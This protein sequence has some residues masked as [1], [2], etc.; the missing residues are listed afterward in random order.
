MAKSVQT[1]PPAGLFPLL[2]EKGNRLHSKLGQIFF[3]QGDPAN[4]LFYIEDG[5]VRVTATSH[6]G[7]EAIVAVLG[8]GDFFGEACLTGQTHRISTVVAVAESS[9]LR[10]EKA[11]V[12]RLLQEDRNFME[13]FLTFLLSRNMRMEADLIDQLFNSCEKRLARVLLLY[14]NFE[15]E[16]KS[17]PVPKVSQATL[18]QMIGSTRSRVSFFMN[19]FR[20][21]GFIDYDGGYSG[22]VEVH[23]SLLNVLLY[24]DPDSHHERVAAASL[25]K[26]NTPQGP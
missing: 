6:Q 4:A 8:T 26:L 5:Q 2:R 20:R 13:R 10:L 11:A 21:L 15:K 25:A 22:H 18:A 24:D 16:G 12:L 23:S 9:I 17:Q 3:S 7:K 14:A 1:L 19:K